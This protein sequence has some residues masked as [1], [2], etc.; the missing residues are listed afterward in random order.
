MRSP[1]QQDRFRQ[2]RAILMRDW[3]PIGVF[4]LPAAQDEYDSYIWPYLRLLDEGTGVEKIAAALDRIE[5]EQ[6]GMGGI[7]T[8]RNARRAL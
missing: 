4:D 2:V 7:L 1:A 6:M 3:D 8:S 5:T